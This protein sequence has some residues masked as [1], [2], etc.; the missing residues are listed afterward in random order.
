MSQAG[1]DK[2]IF[3]QD[4]TMTGTATIYSDRF[5]MRK[6]SLFSLH[7]EWAGSSPSGTLTLWQSNKPDPDPDSV[8][9]W[10]ENTDVTFTSPA[11]SD[12]AEFHTVGNA[13]AKYYMVRYI[14]GSGT[15]VLYC[16]AFAGK[17]A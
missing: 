6:G 4:S 11:G 1:Y 10:V 8:T 7:F 14:N 5:S 2:E 13:A 17:S 3:A 16:Y 12:S 9:D 15:G